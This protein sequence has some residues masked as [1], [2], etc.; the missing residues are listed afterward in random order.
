MQT[1]PK[2]IITISAIITSLTLSGCVTTNAS[3]T[4]GSDYRTAETRKAGEVQYGTLI[5]VRTV[6]IRE[7][8]GAEAANNRSVGTGGAILGG[9]LGSGMGD[10]GSA[11]GALIGMLVG[12][13]AGAVTSNSVSEVDGWEIDVQLA[14]GKT[15]VVVQAKK[16]NENFTNGMKV[17]VVK[18]G[19]TYRVTPV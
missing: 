7:N 18:Y 17:R 4:G 6:S 11:K 14:D 2:R 16:E 5:N 12:A 19:E 15:I 9:T 3:K 8:E 10:S 13:V 1:T